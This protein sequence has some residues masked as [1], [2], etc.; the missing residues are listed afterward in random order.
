[1][2]HSETDVYQRPRLKKPT[3]AGPQPERQTTAFA[4]L[5]TYPK[6]SALV[7]PGIGGLDSLNY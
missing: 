1:M 4:V 6:V 7:Q 3:W 5:A 2:T